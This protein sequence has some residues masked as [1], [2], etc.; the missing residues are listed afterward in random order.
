MAG[1]VAYHLLAQAGA[2]RASWPITTIVS[3]LPV[4]VL[5]MGTALA[6]M[7]GADADT[8]TDGPDH[9]GTAGPT[10]PRSAGWSA[11]DQ[12]VPAQG[13][14]AAPSKSPSKDQ[15]GP[16]AACNTADGT[17]TPALPETEQARL[18]ADRLTA[19]GKR[20]SRRALRSEGI[21]GSNHALNALAAR[22]SAELADA[23]LPASPNDT[24]RD[25]DPASRALR[26]ASLAGGN[27]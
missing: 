14:N 1:Q 4:L 20:V 22:I 27:R 19:A 21:R 11:G 15:D 18:I 9:T 10:A 24:A 25:P 5:G 26:P 12:A 8:T 3:C 23:A 16:T 2:A 6:H 7:L 17:R 13:Q